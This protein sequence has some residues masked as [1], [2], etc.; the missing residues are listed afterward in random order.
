MREGRSVRPALPPRA[1]CALAALVLLAACG[2]PWSGRD[3]EPAIEAGPVAEEVAPEREVVF[4]GDRGAFYR[5]L[6]L[7]DQR[8]F[9]AAD[10]A[11]REAL[12]P[13]DGGTEV[14]TALLL[15]SSLHQDPRN[16]A[17]EPDSAALMAARYLHLSGTPEAGRRLAEGLYVQA[18]D[19]GGDPA[20]RPGT[21]TPGVGLL[22]ARC[23]SAGRARGGVVDL[24]ELE[25]PPWAVRVR[26]VEGRLDSL[27]VV[28][29]AA[30][31]RVMELEAELERIRRLLQDPDTGRAGPP[32]GP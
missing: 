19:R 9:L 5:G 20:L 32:G 11:L 3:P 21:Y 16:A 12:V 27:A 29:D 1:A 25:N 10:S 14:G 4:R 17:A 31:R 18:L 23:G 2:L 7:L 13:C 28:H 24:P 8:R 26:E 15:L 22:S 6:R 30:H